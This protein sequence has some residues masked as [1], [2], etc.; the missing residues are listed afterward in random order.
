M[1]INKKMYPEVFT[2]NEEMDSRDIE[3]FEKMLSDISLSDKEREFF[4]KMK[5]KE[6]GEFAPSA[7]LVL[8][9]D[10]NEDEIFIVRYYY[11]EYK[12]GRG[13]PDNRRRTSIYSIT[14]AEMLESDMFDL[15]DR[16]ITVLDWLREVDFKGINYNGNYILNRH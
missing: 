10:D 13:K 6:E 2:E 1:S 4:I 16:H 8:D 3:L 11:E 7:D 14:L 15:L 9:E 12:V 5:E